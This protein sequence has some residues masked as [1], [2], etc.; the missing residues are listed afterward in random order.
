ML[1]VAHL[2]AALADDFTLGELIESPTARRDR[3][4]WDG[5]LAIDGD[6][7]QWLRR[8]CERTLQPLRDDL[9]VPIL[10][11]SGYRSP[12]LNA[13]LPGS[14][15]R[16]QHCLGQAAD[17]RVPIASARL[18]EKLLGLVPGPHPAVVETS[19]NYVAWAYLASNPVRYDV[20]QVIHE[21]GASLARPAWIHVSCGP[22]RRRELLAIGDLADGRIRLH[23]PADAYRRLRA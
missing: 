9:G 20:D 22:R 11:N 21:H 1:D 12:A 7:L 13:A 14:S 17:I 23:S 15:R 6:A 4:L 18:R 5:Q 10:V 2:S 19:G 8:L 3:E 16:S